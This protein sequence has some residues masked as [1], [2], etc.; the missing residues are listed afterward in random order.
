MS[1]FTVRLLSLALMSF[2]WSPANAAESVEFD[3]PYVTNGGPKQQLDLYTPS[4]DR[5]PT[6]LFVHG[7]SLIEGDRKDAPHDQIARTFQKL[8]IG[9]AAMSYRLAAD[10]RWP[11]QPNDVAAA[12]AWVKRNIAARGGDPQRVFLLGHSSGCLLVS[13]VAADR[14]Y[15][16]EQGFT[17]R[18]VAG[19]IP[20]GCRLCDSVVVAPAAPNGYESSWVPPDRLAEFMESETAFTDLDQRNT[21]VPVRYVDSSLPPTLLLMAEGERFFPPVLRDGAEFVG[22]AL[23]AGADVDLAILADRRH[24]TALEMMITPDDPAVVKVVEFIQ[25]H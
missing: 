11:A 4:A 21:A 13:I 14:Q 3:I 2:L 17:Q 5:F 22:R 24:M 7:G 25:C 10:A 23:E 8:G 9:F 16:G 19:V 18:D 12:F 20:I 6:I 1:R 15:F